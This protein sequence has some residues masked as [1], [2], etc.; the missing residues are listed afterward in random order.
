VLTLYHY[1]LTRIVFVPHMQAFRAAQAVTGCYGHVLISREDA[2]ASFT[3]L[4]AAKQAAA[5]IMQRWTC[6]TNVEDGALAFSSIS[7]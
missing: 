5:P 1:G 2:P 7:Q 6:P 4:E 3:F